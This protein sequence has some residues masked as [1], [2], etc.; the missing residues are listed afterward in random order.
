MGGLEFAV[1]E[2]AGFAVHVHDGRAG[3]FSINASIGRKENE[4]ARIEREQDFWLCYKLFRL[5]ITKKVRW[6]DAG[7]ELTT[8]IDTEIDTE[9]DTEPDE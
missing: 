2:R 4:K 7:V 6:A 8:E 9:V 3:F 1:V 5:A